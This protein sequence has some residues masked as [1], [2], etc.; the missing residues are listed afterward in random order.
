MLFVAA[1]TAVQ[2]RSE[3]RSFS[4]VGSEH[5]SVLWSLFGHPPDMDVAEGR[6]EGPLVGEKHSKVYDKKSTPILQM[7]L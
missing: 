1:A 7:E 6:W 5:T 2:L 3:W 4:G